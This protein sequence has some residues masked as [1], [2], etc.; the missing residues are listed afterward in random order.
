MSA[1]LERVAS[2][3]QANS[4]KESGFPT[5]ASCA[6]Q[7]ISFGDVPGRRRVGGPQAFLRF[8]SP[9][10]QGSE[11]IRR[12][13]QRL[14]LARQPSPTHDPET[15]QEVSNTTASL[16]R[17]IRLPTTSI[18]IP[19]QQIRKSETSVEEGTGENPRLDH[20]CVLMASQNLWTPWA[21]QGIYPVGFGGCPCPRTFGWGEIVGQIGGSSVDL[22]PIIRAINVLRGPDVRFTHSSLA[23]DDCYA[24]DN[25]VLH[26]LLSFF[27]PSSNLPGSVTA[28]GVTVTDGT[29]AGARRS[30][31]T[32]LVM[33][34][35]LKSKA[36]VVV[37]CSFSSPD[38]IRQL[39][40][41]I[42]Y[43]DSCCQSSTNSACWSGTW[44]AWRQVY[45]FL[46]RIQRPDRTHRTWHSYSHPYHHPT[47]QDLHVRHKDAT[48][49]LLP[50]EGSKHREGHWQ[51]WS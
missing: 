40:V 10:A 43:S 20:M 28:G 25:T 34:K 38:V 50:Q 19:E 3:N 11:Q 47:G 17:R 26:F 18:P 7:L 4:L 39:M 6:P 45:G 31:S 8:H 24:L 12:G 32:C 48:Y 2:N 27:V 29:G 9:Q 37:R 16:H 1:H 22:S 30:C 35:A 41:M 46:Q 14:V 5:V 49:V 15:L 36:Q 13:Q 21:D 51:A 33:S 44:C 42:A 23:P